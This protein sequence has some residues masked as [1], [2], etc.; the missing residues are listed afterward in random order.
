MT[1]A[2]Y[3]PEAII[4]DEEVLRV[5][6]SANFGS[7]PPRQVINDGVRKV[8]YGFG[9]GS[10]QYAILFEHGLITKHRSATNRVLRPRL[11]PLGLRY[12]RSVYRYDGGAAVRSEIERAEQS[13]RLAHNY[14]VGNGVD[15]PESKA[16]MHINDAV[17]AVATLKKVIGENT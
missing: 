6:G 1:K 8:A 16:L 15:T 2:V 11:T 13:L 9:T 7:M 12:A 4:S 5:H 10:T 17:C 3:G 14:V